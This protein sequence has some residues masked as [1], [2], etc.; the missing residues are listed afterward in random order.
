MFQ[1]KPI[2]K[3][4]IPEALAKAERY[5]LLNEPRLTESICLDILEIEPDHHDAI[6]IMLLSLTDQFGKTV[7]AN[8]REARQLLPKLNQY[9]QYYY[10]GLICERQAKASLKD[11][12]GGNFTA[13]EWLRDAMSLYEKAEAIRPADNDDSI[14]RWNTC[15][16]LILRNNLQ[17]RKEE[18]VEPAVD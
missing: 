14:L 17:P 7:S 12:G 15:V 1:L 9:E 2:S 16:R 6:V 10:G 5:R 3:S 4:G 8:V 18:Y 13:Y 11:L